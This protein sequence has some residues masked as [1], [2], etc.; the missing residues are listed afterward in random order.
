MY[1]SPRESQK[2]QARKAAAYGHPTQA[3]VDA[4]KRKSQ[5]TALAKLAPKGK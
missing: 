2:V 1:V 5:A 3:Q 4:N